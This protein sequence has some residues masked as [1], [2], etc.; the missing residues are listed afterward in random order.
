M[1]PDCME[2]VEPI[3]TWEEKYHR[4]SNSLRRGT[5][6]KLAPEQLE[7]LGINFD[8]YDHSEYQGG[9]AYIDFKRKRMEVTPEYGK[10]L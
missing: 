9:K 8:P 4:L 1:H 2:F 6:A 5:L 10:I 3:K 7:L